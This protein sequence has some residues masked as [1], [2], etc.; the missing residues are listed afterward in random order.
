MGGGHY[1]PGVTLHPGSPVTPLGLEL[2]GQNQVLQE[3][4]LKKPAMKLEPTVDITTEQV[5][6][7]SN[8][9]MVCWGERLP[10]T[11]EW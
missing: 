9:K 2:S 4:R 5:D 8:Q 10:P 1:H 3:Q 11:T 6:L 7:M